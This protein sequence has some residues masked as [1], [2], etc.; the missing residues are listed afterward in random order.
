[1]CEVSCCDGVSDDDGAV[2]GC[3]LSEMTDE[4][5]KETKL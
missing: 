4:R 3:A 5:N 2:D 1:M